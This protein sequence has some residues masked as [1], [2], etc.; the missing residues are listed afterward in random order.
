MCVFLLEV[1]RTYTTDRN[2]MART[3]DNILDGYDLSLSLDRY[4]EIMHIPISAFNGL[5]NPNE[6]QF[7][8]CATIWKQSGRNH[9]AQYLAWAEEER[10]TELG[11]HLAPKYIV[12]EEHDH[13]VGAIAILHRKKL[14]QVG[15]E[16]TEDIES[17]VSLTLRDIYDAINDPVE[18]T[19]TTPVTSTSEICVY[20]PGEDV[21]IKPSSV[22]ISGGV[23]TIQI[24]RSRLVKPSLMDD[25]EDHLYYVDDDNFMETV[26]VKRCYTSLNGAVTLVWPS[27]Q[28]A[29]LGRECPPG[30]SEQTQTGCASVAGERAKRI[31]KVQV[32]PA[33]FSGEVPSGARWTYGC[34]PWYIRVSYLS[35]SQT[36]PKQELLTARLAHTK[37]PNRPCSCPLVDQY[38]SEDREDG[39]FATPYGNTVGAVNAWLADSRSKIGIGGMM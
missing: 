17:D 13:G 18:I 29:Q 10:E 26:D 14:I 20:Y 5:N 24:P 39:A 7:E 34:P 19:V 11:Y 27:L 2:I 32:F 23:A 15:I 12:D 33:T 28:L 35:G 6:K 21:K 22:S 16:A 30:C 25:R 4:Q 3:T 1:L 8:Q 9:L 36:S 37:M 31:A 38:W